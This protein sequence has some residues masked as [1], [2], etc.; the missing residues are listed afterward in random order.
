M[1][2]YLVYGIGSQSV[3]PRLKIFIGSNFFKVHLLFVRP[4]LLRYLY[5]KLFI[6]NCDKYFFLYISFVINM[7][8]S[9][10]PIFEINVPSGVRRVKMQIGMH[11]HAVWLVFAV[12][13]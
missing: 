13:L 10:E 9:F 11:I 1:Y 2:F 12:C 7:Y 8:L 6:V 4:Q 5:L 3:Y